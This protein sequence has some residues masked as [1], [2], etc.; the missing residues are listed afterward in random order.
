[1]TLDEYLEVKH[2]FSH[3]LYAK[4]M[5]LKEGEIIATHKHTFAHISILAKGIV[6]VECNGE[7]KI[8]EAGDCVEISAGLEHRIYALDDVVWFCIHATNETDAEKIDETL[9]QG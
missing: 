2:H 6:R 8:Y 3:G 1:M 5:T 4:R 9:I 7:S